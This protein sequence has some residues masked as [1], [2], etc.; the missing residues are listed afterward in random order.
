VE[1][2]S[3]IRAAASQRSGGSGRRG[4]DHHV[5]DARYSATSAMTAS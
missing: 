1:H 5:D 4:L 3:P 2:R